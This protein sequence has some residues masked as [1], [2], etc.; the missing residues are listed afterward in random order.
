M[1]AKVLDGKL[2]AELIQGRLKERVLQREH[3]KL[4]IP[5]LAVV[6]VGDDPASGTYVQNKIRA[7]T[8]LGMEAELIELPE[9]VSQSKLRA[10]VSEVNARTDVH[11]IIMQLPIPANLDESSIL[12]EIS[13]VKDVDGLTSRSL[14]RLV[15]GFPVHLPA[16]PLAV[17]EIMKHFNIF[18]EGKHVVVVGRSLLVGRPISIMLSQRVADGNATVTV[19]HRG[20]QDL[21]KLI[22]TADI[23]IVATGSPNSIGPEMLNSRM[24]VIDVG[25]NW[26]ADET[27]KSGR[28]LVGD[29][30]FDRALPIVEAITPVPGGIGPMTVTMLLSNTLNAAEMQ[31]HL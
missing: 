29:V 23:L 25:T 8:K 20:T 11:G 6:K 22:A 30:D 13:T 31:D 14:G 12:D 10:T 15:V 4:P 18:P 2:V 9:S 7:A 17:V 27:R 19:A 3:D 24:T 1:T 28:R 16:T 5:K 26:I 21:K